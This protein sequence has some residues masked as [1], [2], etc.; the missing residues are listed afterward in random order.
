[1]PTIQLVDGFGLSLQATPDPISA[2]LKYFSQIPRISA[3]QHNLAALQDFPLSGFPLKSVEIGL[4]ANPPATLQVAGLPLTL[5]GGVSGLLRVLTDGNLFDPDPYGDPV[6]IPDHA[7]YVDLGI[8]ASV[9]PGAKF[10]AGELTYGFTAGATLCL[11][12]YKR[13]ETTSAAPT[14][15][16]ALETSFRAYIIPGTPEDLAGMGV[17]DI[18]TIEGSGKLQ[19]SGDFNLL[20]VVNPLAGVSSAVQSGGI[21]IQ[22]GASVDVGA[23]FS[24]EGEY[25]IRVQ[26]VASRKVHIGF[27]TKRGADLTVQASASV[28]VSAGTTNVDFIS[29]VLGAL[30]PSP[31]ASSTGLAGTGLGAEK[32]EAICDALQAGVQRKLELAIE[33]ELHAGGSRGAAFLYEIDFDALDVQGHTAVQDALRLNLS[34]L[35]KSAGAS[36]PGISEIR[37]I[38]TT[39]RQKSLALKLNLLGIYNYT[40]LT[41]LAKHGKVLTDPQSGE[42]VITDTATATR[43]AAAVNFLAD[44]AKLRKILAQSFLLTAAY[45]CSKLIAQPPSVKAAYWHFAAQ[46][47]T[48]RGTMADDLNVLVALGLISAARKQVCLGDFNDFGNS[49]FYVNT[50]YDDALA[51]SL[52]LRSGGQPRGADEYEALGRQA[53]KLLLQDNADAAYRLP[54]LSD[55]AIWVKVK[56]TGGTLVNLAAALPGLTQNVQIPVIAGDYVLIAWWATT[57][58]RMS[59]SLAS[60]RR[61]F[62]QDPPPSPQSPEFAK[63]QNDLWNEMAEVTAN[64]QDRFA[65][66][67][68]L[69]AMDLASG[70]QSA[71]NARITSPH[72]SLMVE[73][74]LK[75]P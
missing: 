71:A 63:T 53:L 74:Q 29:S 1:M 75:N 32:A 20:T 9:S 26:K 46:A 51:E 40:S 5:G 8:K 24:V 23:S 60:A 3:V 72:L 2:F 36:L 59:K 27:Y 49:S 44:S 19:F 22:E 15:V 11:S 67:W 42:V 52:F 55:D 73:R 56:E 13:F 4:T 50:D 37:S 33:A 39:A 7:A 38:V 69:L 48:G 61:F 68:G 10:G 57:M 66:P 28:G 41:E 64:T 62:A 30:T 25:Q 18:A 70:Q 6:P 65:E 58:A 47:K 54:P 45:R 12:H 34:A 31:F 16:S 35:M 43:M 21:E 14:L 17:G